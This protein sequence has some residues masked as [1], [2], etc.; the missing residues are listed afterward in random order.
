MIAEGR[1]MRALAAQTVI[2][3]LGPVVGR[4]AGFFLVPIYLHYAGTNAYGTV[5]LML[6]AV[7]IAAILLRLG[8]SATMS[9]FTLGE[10]ADDFSPI[11]HTIFTFVMVASTLGVIVGFIL[12]DWIGRVLQVD[13]DI[14]L[15]GLL[16]LWISMNYDVMGRVYRIQRRASAWMKL[17]FLNVILTIV[18]TLLLVVVFRQGALGLLVGNFTGTALVYVLVLV[19]RRDSI[20]VSR[21]DTPVLREL[22]AYSLPLMPANLAL[23]A[24]NLADRIQVQRLASHHALGVYSVAARVAVP[25]LVLMAAFQTAWAPF[26]HDVR[27]QEGDEQAKRTYASVLSY[28]SVVMGWGL[29]V[30][31]LLAPPYILY[32]MPKSAHGA[33]PVVTML[34]AGIVLYGGYLIV[35]VGV[36][37]SKRTRMTP[38][39]C[40]IAAAVNV[41]LNFWVIPRYGI[42]GAGA[43]TVIGYAVL[44]V[45]GWL[46]A[47]RGYPVPYDWARVLRVTMV[48]VVIIALSQWVIPGTGIVAVIVRVL[49]AAVFP[50]ALVPVGGLTR[51][52]VRKGRSML[53]RW[54]GRAAEAAT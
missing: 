46:N 24:L 33:V 29:V 42:K 34:A 11:V 31:T 17:T 13:T 41:G 38:I 37:I 50:L 12:R 36:S 19:L 16:G 28:W 49:L 40:A 25:A 22:L 48:V 18:L 45:L 9:R 53:T 52:D 21:F 20:G 2:Y 43:T 47:E 10:A 8:I 32:A 27:G 51:A 1:R 30:I 3:G 26:A 14:V 7:T 35:S 5:D 44:L 54:R 6:A 39:I 4:F 23:W 15:A